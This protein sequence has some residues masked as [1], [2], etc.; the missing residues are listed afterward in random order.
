[1]IHDFGFEERREHEIEILCKPKRNI[2]A[3]KLC[4]QVPKEKCEQFL[5]RI[6]LN[7]EHQTSGNKI[8]STTELLQKNNKWVFQVF[9]QFL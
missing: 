5:V 3:L 9:L 8:F 7:I 2:K 6:K 4:C 1:L